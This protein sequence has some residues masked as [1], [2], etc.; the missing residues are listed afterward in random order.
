MSLITCDKIIDADGE[1][2]TVCEG[3]QFQ[4]WTDGYIQCIEC[5]M[6]KVIE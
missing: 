2:P 4:M 6:E 5:A 1:F 3:S